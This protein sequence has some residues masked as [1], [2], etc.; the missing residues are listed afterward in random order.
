MS[1]LPL[2]SRSRLG[3]RGLRPLSPRCWP[4]EPFGRCGERATP[5]PEQV[6]FHITTDVALPGSGASAISPDGR[7]LAFLGIAPDGTQRVWVR[8]LN[9]LVDRALPGSRLDQAAAPPFWSPDSRLNAFDGGGELRKIDASGGLAQSVCALKSPVVGGSRNSEGTIIIGTV[10]EG[11][12]RVNEAGGTRRAGHYRGRP[13]ES[14]H[15]LPV[16]LS[17]GRRF[18]YLRIS[19]GAP[20]RTGIFVG[21]LDVPS[22]Q[23]DRRR[24]LATST[25]VAYAP[26]GRGRGTLFFLRDGNLTAQAFDERATELTGVA[27]PGGPKG[28]RHTSIVRRFRHRRT[29]CRHTAMPPACS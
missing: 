16:F 8:D 5:A 4:L 9:A 1:R 21:S 12:L 27:G 3:S 24:L 19:R 25:S 23:Q 29:G 6:R 2:L 20:E 14:A 18:L 17:D 11:I 13:Q 10:S 7:H 22:D 26:T 15:M 28:V